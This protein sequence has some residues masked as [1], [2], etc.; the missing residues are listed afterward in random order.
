MNQEPL[1]A[2]W[3]TFIIGLVYGYAIGLFIMY[4]R[5]RKRIS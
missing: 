4:F 5:I 2:D 1:I 3:L